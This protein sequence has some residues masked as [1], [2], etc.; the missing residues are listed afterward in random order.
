IQ[1]LSCRDHEPLKSVALCP[2]PGIH[3]LPPRPKERATVQSLFQ[4]TANKLDDSPQAL[5]AFKGKV[6]LIVN[7]ASR[8]G[9]TPQYAGLEKLHEEYQGKGLEVLGFPS[10]EFGAQEPGTAQEIAS[11]C[12]LNFGVKFP[13]FEK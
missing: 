7:T 6:L 12:T 10:N 2:P 11:F 13:L 9:F 1:P 5:D 8:C 3:G 4:L